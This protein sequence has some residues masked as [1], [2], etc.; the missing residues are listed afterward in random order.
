M[1]ISKSKRS[2][3][4]KYT[5]CTPA[6]LCSL[7]CQWQKSITTGK[8]TPAQKLIAKRELKNIATFLRTSTSKQINEKIKMLQTQ[9]AKRYNVAVTSTKATSAAAKRLKLKLKQIKKTMN[10]LTLIKLCAAIKLAT[11]KNPKGKKS[12][13][14][15]TKTRT[16]NRVKSR[17]TKSRT[18][19]SSRTVTAK[20]KKQTKSLKKEITKLKQRN[21]FMKKLVAKFRKE[22]AQLQ[23]HY[24]TLHNKP[25]W[26][27][28][29]GKNVGKEVSNIVSF[30]NA[31]SNVFTKQQQRKVG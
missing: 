23:R 20:Y 3:T 29:Q 10:V 4:G 11:Y 2:T 27:V 14:T 13:T 1:S 16:R 22:V 28:V 9:M 15:T 8:F 12:G 18:T 24:G 5:R 6:K 19:T 7:S 26:K 25:R 31:L 30:S 21:T 17:T